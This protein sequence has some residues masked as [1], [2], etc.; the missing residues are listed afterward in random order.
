VEPHSALATWLYYEVFAGKARLFIHHHEYYAPEDFARPGMR[1]LRA[2]YK[3][4]RR[5]LFRRAEWISQ[6]NQQRLT[7]LK[8]A[9]P[10]VDDSKGRVWPNYPTRCWAQR[11]RD[12][13]CERDS[14]RTRFLYLGSASLEDTFIG[15]F[16]RWIA[17]HPNETS[18]HVV[19]NNISR[20]V[21][22]DLQSLGASNIVLN[23]AGWDYE[24]I[25]SLA[26]QFDVGVV[27]YKGNTKNFVY[28]VPNKTIEYLAAGLNVWYPAQMTSMR[29]FETSYP[30]LPLLQMNFE[31]LPQRVPSLRQLNRP[32]AFPFTSENAIAPLI[33]AI[34]HGNKSVPG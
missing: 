5:D 29:E 14:A 23:D 4:E 10:L 18:L 27:L 12:R 19:S 11:A 20:D 28:N 26:S 1:V 34:E 32:G 17:G 33:S 24:E 2:T 8:Q 31:A 6:T 21:W 22:A 25:P 13:K 9:Y 3:L 30:D 7:L 16:A 15:E